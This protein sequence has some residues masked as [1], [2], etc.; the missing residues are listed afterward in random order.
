MMKYMPYV[1]GFMLGVGVTTI[2]WI[3]S[4]VEIRKNSSVITNAES[5]CTGLGFNSYNVD[6]HGN[7]I[8]KTVI[9]NH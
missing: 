6:E 1:V 7:V 9:K 4:T 5:F 8:C 3:E 2:T